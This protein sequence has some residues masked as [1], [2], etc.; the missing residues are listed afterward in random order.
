[1]AAL[2]AKIGWKNLSVLGW[3]KARFGVWMNSTGWT[4]Y[5]SAQGDWIRSMPQAQGARNQ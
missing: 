2:A 4:R 3:P 5:K 1:M